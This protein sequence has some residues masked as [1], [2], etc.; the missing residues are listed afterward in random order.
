MIGQSASKSSTGLPGTASGEVQKFV[1]RARGSLGE[2]RK[3][4]QGWL[5]R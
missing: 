2:S 4:K 3:I 5:V 1:L